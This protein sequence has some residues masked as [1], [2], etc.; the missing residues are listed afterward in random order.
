MQVVLDTNVLIS[1][2]LYKGSIGKVQ[3]QDASVIISQIR[4]IDV[5]R[6]VEKIGF[7][8]KEI[9]DGITKAVK[10]LL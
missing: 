9:F 5:K 7:L 6:L 10:D 3:D 8:N 1:A 4:V 2:L